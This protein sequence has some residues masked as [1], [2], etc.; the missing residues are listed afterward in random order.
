MRDKLC[1]YDCECYKNLWMISVRL[2]CGEKKVEEVF[3]IEDWE[4]GLQYFS[5]TDYWY[6]GF[7]SANYDDI[8]IAYWLHLGKDATHELMF[9]MNQ[10]LIEEDWNA[11]LI[12]RNFIHENVSEFTYTKHGQTRTNRSLIPNSP[13]F[14]KFGGWERKTVDLYML[15]EKQGSLKNA[16]TVLGVNSL[17]EA[18]VEFGTALTE[19]EKALVIKYCWNDVDVTEKAYDY[20]EQAMVVRDEFFIQYGIKNAHNIGSAKLA[21]RYLLSM[22]KE[23]IGDKYASWMNNIEEYMESVNNKEI[24]R[25]DKVTLITKDYQH[26]YVDANFIKFW[27]MLKQSYL[28]YAASTVK[29]VDVWIDEA[30]DFDTWRKDAKAPSQYYIDGKSIP[31][32]SLLIEDSRNNVYKFGIGGLHNDAPKGLWKT[33]DKWVIWN[34]DVTSYYPS[35]ISANGFA[36]ELFPEF[37]GYIKTLL[38]ERKSAKIAKRMTESDS[39]KLVL[40]SSFGKTKDRHSPLYDPLCHF[41]VTVNGQLLLLRLIDMIHQVS[42]EAKLINAN[43]DGVCFY[44]PKSDLKAA[45]GMCMAWESIARVNLEE[46]F[47]DVWYQESCNGYCAKMN[48]GKIKSKGGDFKL[49]P[50]SLKETFAKSP[51]LKKALVHYVLN[52]VPIETTLTNLE[53]ADFCMTMTF[54]SKTQLII[55][56]KIVRKK[57]LR[58]VYVKNGE[59]FGKYTK[60]SGRKSIVGQGRQL[61][62]VDLLSELDM[63]DV[64]ITSYAKDVKEMLLENLM[65]RKSKCLPKKIRDNI[66]ENF[67]Q[68]EDTKNGAKIL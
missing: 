3:L 62:M 49:K 22:H 51:A 50:S 39:K 34:V 20:Y 67:K 36:P 61:K 19:D 4:A 6:V 21:E 46:E 42:A 11:E 2:R 27:D 38:A 64:D 41:S 37:S 47:Y 1:L 54:G 15:G 5:N 55:G 13:A 58:Y 23:K 24:K 28:S 16:A 25:G 35:L 12:T 26:S 8:M 29:G 7:N 53:P 57:V 52:N 17:M 56:D 68:W 60:S 44:I 43:T 10:Y 59:T 9:D 32:G 18:P 63:N 45:Q 30:V 40:N 66:A 31:Q 14:N 33:D 48:N 65:E